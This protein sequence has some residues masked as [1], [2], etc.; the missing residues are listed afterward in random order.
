MTGI[1]QT[2]VNGLYGNGVHPKDVEMMLKLMRELIEVQV[3]VSEDPRRMLRAGSSSFARL[4][5]FYHESSFSAK[6]FLTAALL[7]PLMA[8]LIEDDKQMEID[9]KVRQKLNTAQLYDLVMKFIK[10]LIDNWM[11]FP[12]TLRWLVQTMCHFLKMTHVPENNINAILTDMVFT[13]FICPAIVSPEIYGIIDAPISETAR[14]NLMQIGQILQMLSLIKYQKPDG[15]F[16]DLCDRFQ[17][18]PGMVSIF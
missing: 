18:I 15:K 5:H 6:L 13:H 1:I 12:S 9:D 17:S 14:Y 11:L 7:E 3:A 16:K 8:V 2:I 10:S 4:Y